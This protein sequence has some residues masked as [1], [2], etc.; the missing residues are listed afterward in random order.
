MISFLYHV[1]GWELKHSLILG[2]AID[3]IFVTLLVWSVQ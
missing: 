3:I 2:S 1:L